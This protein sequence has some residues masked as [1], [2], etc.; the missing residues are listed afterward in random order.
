MD[1]LVTTTVEGQPDSHDAN[2]LFLKWIREEGHMP[3][4]TVLEII[5]SAQTLHSDSGQ[6]F[7]QTCQAIMHLRIEK[8]KLFLQMVR[9]QLFTYDPLSIRNAIKLLK[10][11]SGPMRYMLAFA[12][13]K[14]VLNRGNITGSVRMEYILNFFEDR[15]PKT[16]IEMTLTDPR[17]LNPTSPLASNTELD[18]IEPLKFWDRVNRLNEAGRLKVDSVVSNIDHELSESLKKHD[19]TFETLSETRRRRLRENAIKSDIDTAIATFRSHLKTVRG[20]GRGLAHSSGN[21]PKQLP[22]IA[23]PKLI[24]AGFDVGAYTRMR[25]SHNAGKVTREFM[26]PD[27]AI[28][29]AKKHIGKFA[30]N[31]ADPPPP[32][33]QSLMTPEQRLHHVLGTAPPTN[34]LSFLAYTSDE[35]LPSLGHYSISVHPD[36][37]NVVES[38]AYSPP[39]NYINMYLTGHDEPL[40]VFVD[41]GG[42]AGSLMDMSVAKR[43]KPNCLYYKQFQETEMTTLNGAGEGDR[44][45]I[46]GFMGFRATFNIDD[47]RTKPFIAHFKVV[48]GLHRN[49]PNVHIGLPDFPYYGGLT[50]TAI[51][52]GKTYR[53][54]TTARESHILGFKVPASAREHSPFTYVSNAVKEADFQ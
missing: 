10:I 44:L 22:F 9:D 28:K 1:F 33:N 2:H 19:I 32:N 34:K 40:S 11:G 26:T 18:L 48:S 25:N 3:N 35:C 37:V 5:H 6:P 41:S 51:L 38:P 31:R 15:V 14:E 12:E 43:L 13:L 39:G 53:A 7:S 29:Y 8:L 49:A 52:E 42:L 47:L 23:K 30:K 17:T 50:T 46:I 45:F 27:D 4:A 21:L 36:F 16:S 20:L 54:L 24:A